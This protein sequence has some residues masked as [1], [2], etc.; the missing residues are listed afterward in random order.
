MID[1]LVERAT[2]VVATPFDES[3]SVYIVVDHMYFIGLTRVTAK[4]VGEH[5][6]GRGL[7]GA[8]SLQVVCVEHGAP[9]EQNI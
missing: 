7:F 9:E 3:L 5:E 1:S 4:L 2:N 8:N 6:A